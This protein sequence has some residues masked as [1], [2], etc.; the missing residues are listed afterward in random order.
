ME[1][2]EDN[3]E[4]GRVGGK[5][6]RKVK[7]YE[8][9]LLSATGKQEKCNKS[10]S[11]CRRARTFRF[12]V[13]ICFPIILRRKNMRKTVRVK[14]SDRVEDRGEFVVLTD[15]GRVNKKTWRTRYI[16]IIT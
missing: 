14:T 4:R 8:E 9:T 13:C 12:I 15:G 10:L 16:G 3:T 7:G 5:M 6:R 2:S 1:R 11:R